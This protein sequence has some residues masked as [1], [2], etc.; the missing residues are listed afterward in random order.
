MTGE[1]SKLLDEV[2]KLSGMDEDEDEQDEENF[3]E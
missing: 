3:L 2:F 1:K